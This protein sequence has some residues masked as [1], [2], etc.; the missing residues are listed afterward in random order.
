MGIMVVL[1]MLYSSLRRKTE[2]RARNVALSVL[3]FAAIAL[4]LGYCF[5]VSGDLFASIHTTEWSGLYTA[6]SFVL[7]D[8]PQM[9]LKAFYQIPL[10]SWPAMEYWL[11]PV[12][13]F[14][15]LALPP[16]LIYKLRKIDGTLALYSLA[17][18][19][20]FVAFGAIVSAPRFASVLFPLWLPLTAKLTLKSKKDLV[21]I[22][23][24]LVV[25]FALSLDMW[26]SFLNGQFV[27]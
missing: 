6:P 19:V 4:W 17:G 25:F 7:R 22:V 24:V 5:T 27:A 9:G 8:L 1:P 20:G 11:S 16:F 15:G 13:M 14:L 21:L 23:A 10:Q 12:G 18:Y 26:T 3:P 2:H